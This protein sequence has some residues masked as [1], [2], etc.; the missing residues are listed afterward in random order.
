MEGFRSITKGNVAFLAVDVDGFVRRREIG[1]GFGRN[2]ALC[3]V[4]ARMVVVEDQQE[5]QQQGKSHLA[6]N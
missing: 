5:S 4:A 1:A 2:K 3:D 6:S